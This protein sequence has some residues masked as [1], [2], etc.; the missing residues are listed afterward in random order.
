MN[1]PCDFRMDIRTIFLSRKMEYFPRDVIREIEFFGNGAT[2][3]QFTYITT[4]A[5]MLTYET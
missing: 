5:T 1:V 3:K 2:N 4:K